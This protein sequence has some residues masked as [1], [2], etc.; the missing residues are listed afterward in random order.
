[1]LLE[2]DRKEKGRKD[3][4][5]EEKKGGRVEGRERK[6]RKESKKERA[7][8]KKVRLFQREMKTRATRIGTE[9]QKLLEMGMHA[10]HSI[11]ILQTPKSKK[12][13]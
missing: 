7:E 5:E 12:T 1:M 2:L 13:F 9:P 8:R 11:V 3:V 4:R 6:K 10:T